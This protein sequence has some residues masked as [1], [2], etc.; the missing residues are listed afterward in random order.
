MIRRIENFGNNTG[1]ANSIMS[2]PIDKK[3]EWGK[4]VGTAMNIIFSV[5]N[6]LN[7]IELLILCNPTFMF[8]RCHCTKKT[9]CSLSIGRCFA[10][11]D[12]QMYDH[13]YHLKYDN[14]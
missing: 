8:T 7:K 10:C 13:E 14:K 5:E 11:F 3:L 9:H 2:V 4:A 12:E 1:S 6:I